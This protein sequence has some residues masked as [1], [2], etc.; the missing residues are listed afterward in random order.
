MKVETEIKEEDE[1]NPMVVFL[2]K[3]QRVKINKIYGG[4]LLRLIH[5]R[6]LWL[7]LTIMIYFANGEKS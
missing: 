7:N 5:H 4:P 3:D 2:K 6:H 1:K